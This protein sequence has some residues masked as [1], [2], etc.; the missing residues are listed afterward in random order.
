MLN[1]SV[2]CVIVGLVLAP[3]ALAQVD[4]FI[5]NGHTYKLFS[6]ADARTWQNAVI[7]AATQSVNGQTGYLARVDDAAEN[8][9]IFQ[10]VNANAGVL[11][12]VAPD[13]GG[14]RYVWLGA[15]DIA[16]EGDWRWH[17]NNAAFW[18]GGPNGSAVGGLFNNWASLVGP[19]QTEP[20]NF[21]AGAAGQDAAGMSV[22]GYPLG[23]AGQWND[24][25]AT[26]T[27]P[28]VVEFSAVPEP[29]APLAL[30]ALCLG[31]LRRR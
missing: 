5:H 15:N 16:T 30:I 7:F 19:G 22:N 21:P 9:R 29:G 3:S 27:L 12:S 28:F 1:R 14:G 11:T 26:N 10:S 18:S 24:I 20:D 17:D 8:V 4:T 31:L 25:A 2:F 23:S 13:G 6:S